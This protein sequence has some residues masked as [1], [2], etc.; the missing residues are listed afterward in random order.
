MKKQIA[1]RHFSSATLMSRAAAEY[2]AETLSSAANSR[3]YATLV[4]AGGSTPGQLYGLLASEDYKN[5][6]P[7][8]KIYCFWGD[9]RFVPAVHKYSNYKMAYEALLSRVPV[10]PENI[11]PVPV[12]LGWRESASAYEDSLKNFFKQRQGSEDSSAVCFDLVLL[13]VGGDGHTASIFPGSPALGGQ[14]WVEAVAAP[15]GIRPRNPITLTPALF[16][17]ARQ[18]LFLAAEGKKEIVERI[19]GKAG[20]AAEGFPAAKISAQK[21]VSVFIADRDVQD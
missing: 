12:E 17:T 1:V 16:N 18:V 20:G 8:A 13:G 9:E 3:G 11:Y 5:K 21:K 19:F 2:V 6:I 4:L 7:W 15:V 14:R 10:A